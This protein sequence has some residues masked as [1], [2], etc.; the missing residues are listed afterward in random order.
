MLNIDDPASDMRAN[1]AFGD[2]RFVGINDYSCNAPIRADSPLRPMTERYG[3]RCLD[4]T[5]DM[6]EGAEYEKLVRV[7]I[8]YAVAYNQH[9][10]EHIVSLGV[11]AP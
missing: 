1:V 11:D 2:Y 7:A 5:T 9:L 8:R 3:V 10:Y 4:G 6:S